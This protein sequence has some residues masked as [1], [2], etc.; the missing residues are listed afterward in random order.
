MVTS[1]PEM[2]FLYYSQ[3]HS[4]YAG[5]GNSYIHRV[6]NVY[7]SFSLPTQFLL[8][9]APLS[10]LLLMTK[11]YAP[12]PFRISLLRLK[13]TFSFPLTKLNK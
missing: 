5:S 4:T 12:S 1:V 7:L 2:S 13:H 8:L 10:T 9:L 11:Q 3:C 6:S